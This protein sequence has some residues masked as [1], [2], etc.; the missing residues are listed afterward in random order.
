MPRKRSQVKEDPSDLKRIEAEI[1]GTRRE[2][3][4]RMLRFL[5]ESPDI[6]LSEVAA[7]LNRPER[8][9]RR[10][11]QFYLAGGLDAVLLS[12]AE[13]GKR[14]SQLAPEEVEAFRERARSGFSE[15]AEAQQWLVQE[16]G[17]E[18]SLPRVSGLMKREGLSLAASQK[19]APVH[20]ITDVVPVTPPVDLVSFL[21]A[22]PTS[23]DP[24]VWI[25]EFSQLLMRLLVDVDR[26]SVNI[27]TQLNISGKSNGS[28]VRFIQHPSVDPGSTSLLTCV[29][30]DTNSSPSLQLLEDFKR[31]KC[32][33]HLY[34]QPVA[35][36]YYLLDGDGYLGSLILWRNQG[37]NMISPATLALL[38]QLRPFITFAF[39]DGVARNQ[40]CYPDHQAFHSTLSTLATDADLTSQEYRILALRLLGHSYKEIAE[41]ICLS[42]DTIRKHI[43]RIHR[44]AQTRNQTELFAR[45]F[46]SR[47]W[48]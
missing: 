28:F 18:Y 39:T 20:Q 11:W 15:L 40:C 13:G 42:I 37:E 47:K 25:Q 30:F 7:I 2:P 10:W 26:I 34:Q 29:A 24:V 43:Y 17:V 14:P 19:A 35:F 41:L 38:E 31:K 8:T 46:S 1:V 21:N 3:A 33:V 48:A 16:F 23:M 12:A 36:D 5:A 22:L 44:K 6:T 32:P 4:I 27:N 45:Y 9:V